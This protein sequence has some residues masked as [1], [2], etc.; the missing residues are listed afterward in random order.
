MIDQVT[1]RRKIAKVEFILLCSFCT[2]LFDAEGLLWIHIVVLERTD[3][4]PLNLLK[5]DLRE[6]TAVPGASD[7][8]NY[9]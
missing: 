7:Q 2:K 9:V 4:S 5:F 1:L 8:L 3:Q 6:D